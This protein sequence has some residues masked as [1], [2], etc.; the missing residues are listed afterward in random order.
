MKKIS[1]YH[2]DG[3]QDRSYELN[4]Y[5]KFVH[6]KKNAQMNKTDTETETSMKN[7]RYR[8]YLAFWVKFIK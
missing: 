7:F 5:A 8:I 1:Q 6:E 2:N 3:K 4:F